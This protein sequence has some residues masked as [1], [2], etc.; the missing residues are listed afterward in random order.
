[1]NFVLDADGRLETLELMGARFSRKP[2]AETP[3][4]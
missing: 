1:V 3:S 2:A 4:K